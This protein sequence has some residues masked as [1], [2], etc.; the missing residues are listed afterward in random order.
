MKRDGMRVE[1]KPHP[2]SSY[3][4]SGDEMSDE[5]SEEEFSE[6]ESWDEQERKAA[7]KYKE[8]ALDDDDEGKG[9]KRK[10]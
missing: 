2:R 4:G 8:N 6:A 7:K 5:G 3:V 10:R 1:W 9:K